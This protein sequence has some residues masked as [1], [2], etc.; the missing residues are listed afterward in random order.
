MRLRLRSPQQTPVQVYLWRPGR[1][2]IAVFLLLV[3]SW[4]ARVY[5][6]DS[7]GYFQVQRATQGELEGPLYAALRMIEQFALFA[8]VLLTAYAW[9]QNK[10]PSK[11]LVRLVMILITIEFIY[12]L[13]SGRKEDTILSIMMPVATIYL[14]TGLRPSRKATVLFVCFV[15][16]FF[17]LSHYYRLAIELNLTNLSAEEALSL[18]DLASS[19]ADSA[20]AD[21]RPTDVIYNRVSLLEPISASMRLI[22]Q[23]TWPMLLGQ[24]YL[25]VLITVIPRVFWPSKPEFHYGNEFGHAAGYLGTD[26][27]ATSI[28]VSYF[29]EAFLNLAWFGGLAMFFISFLFTVIFKLASTSRDRITGAFIFMLC[30]PSL[31]YLGGTFALYFGGLIKTLPFFYLI[32]SWIR[33]RKAC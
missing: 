28:S 29:G 9:G 4:A 31:L 27:E 7:D 1:V 20:Q 23:G 11:Q 24:S 18:I 10:P 33:Q 19:S 14:L 17:P 21:I 12:W 15:A 5:I 25:E 6:I 13:P 22:Q 30:V 3:A 26:D 16:L 8:V 32:C 2:K